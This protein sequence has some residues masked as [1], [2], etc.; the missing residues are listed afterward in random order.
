MHISE[1]G[2]PNRAEIPSSSNPKKGQPRGGC[3]TLDPERVRF[4]SDLFPAFVKGAPNQNCGA[5]AG[6]GNLQFLGPAGSF[7][8]ARDLLTD[9]SAFQSCDRLTLLCI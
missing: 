9:A 3:R 5:E 6:G 1:R 2:P 7:R 4:Q 8:I